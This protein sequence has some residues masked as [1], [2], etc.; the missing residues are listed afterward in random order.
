MVLNLNFTIRILGYCYGNNTITK[1]SVGFFLSHDIC[2]KVCRVGE[3]GRGQLCCFY[4]LWHLGWCKLQY[5]IYLH[6][7]YNRGRATWNIEY[8]L[9]GLMLK[10]ELQY[11][12]HLMRRAS[13]LERPWCWEGLRTRGEGGDRGWGGWMA[14]LTQWN[15]FEQT[16]EDSEGQWSLMCC[17]SWGSKESDMTWWLNNNTNNMVNCFWTQ[18]FC[19]EVSCATMR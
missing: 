10:L 12:G 5:N 14:S 8:S 6:D 11:F 7:H 13:S 15:E 16:Q 2:P 4:T 3:L 1:I 18:T 9:E 17:S 19:P